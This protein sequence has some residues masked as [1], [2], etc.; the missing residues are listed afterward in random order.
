[1]LS[2]W[3]EE[4]DCEAD[5]VQIEGP[6]L[7][8]NFV[9]QFKGPCVFAARRAKK[10]HSLLRQSDGPWRNVSVQAP[11]GEDIGNY[12]GIDRYPEQQQAE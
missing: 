10:A 6:K 11:S 7:G 4:A 12:I 1:M 3:L 9:L 2:E 5:K 8:R